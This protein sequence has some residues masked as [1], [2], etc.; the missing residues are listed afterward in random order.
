MA[1]LLGI[2][3]DLRNPGQWH[4]AP[5]NHAARSLEIVEY[6]ERLGADAVWATEHHFFPDA[7]LS[8]PLTYAAAVA[9]RTTRVRVGTAV[10]LGALRHPRH[11]AEQAALVDALSGGRLELGLGAGYVAAEYDAFDRDIGRRFTSTD[12]T[13]AEVARLLAT[14]QLGALTVQP[15]IP[16]WL[17]YQGPRN[18]RRAGRLGAGLLTLNRSSLAPY[19]D[20]LAEAGLSPDAARMGG[21]VDIVV[22]DD[23]EA[24]WQRVRPHYAH[25]LETYLH[26][27]DPSA[28]LPPGALDDRFAAGRPQGISVRLSVL[29]P[30]EAVAEIE[31]RIAGLPVAHVYTWA[32]IAGMDDSLVDEHLRLLFGEV[33][34]RLRATG[35]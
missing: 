7:Y 20:G 22:A 18:A 14:D 17:G 28:R 1:P 34:P 25:Q 29:S 31:R 21:S 32:S 6:A 10:L 11:V 3:V 9:A 2:F 5:A 4:R 33:A 30:D 35:A 16:M 8:Q 15:R 23:P 12:N 27:H 26:A 13:F 24:A 19:H